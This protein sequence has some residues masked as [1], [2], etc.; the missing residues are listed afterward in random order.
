M[1][2]LGSISSSGLLSMMVKFVIFHELHFLVKAI[3][4]R[5][6]LNLLTEVPQLR[7]DLPLMMDEF[8]PL[9][10]DDLYR[11]FFFNIKG[12]LDLRDDFIQRSSYCLAILSA[13]L[14]AEIVSTLLIISFINDSNSTCKS[15]FWRAYFSF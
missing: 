14:A 13:Q 5:F 9:F 4:F 1:R 2:F 15:H 6:S 11:Q 12:P 10:S 8:M 3:L 7:F